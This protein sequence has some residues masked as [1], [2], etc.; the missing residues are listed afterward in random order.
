[1][2]DNIT[3]VLFSPEKLKRR[4]SVSSGEMGWGC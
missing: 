4:K 2:S 1:M 3:Y